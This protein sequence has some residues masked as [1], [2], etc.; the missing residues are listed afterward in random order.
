M[1]KALWEERATSSSEPGESSQS[2]RAGW[3]M[4][5]TESNPCLA[6]SL[7]CVPEIPL[8]KWQQL[9]ITWVE[10]KGDFTG[11]FVAGLCLFPSLQSAFLHRGSAFSPH[12]S[13]E[14]TTSHVCGGIL[15]S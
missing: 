14:P 12:G 7:R 15:G 4:S 9:N 13:N 8:G 1:G 2:F 6:E 3:Q 5:G 10:Q 11:S